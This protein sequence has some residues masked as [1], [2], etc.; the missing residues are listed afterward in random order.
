[1]EEEN[2]Q[3]GYGLIALY[4]QTT[5]GVDKVRNMLN[6]VRDLV[7]DLPFLNNDQNRKKEIIKTCINLVSFIKLE[8]DAIYVPPRIFGIGT[9]Q[10]RYEN[11]NKSIKKKKSV[12][13]KKSTKKKSVFKKKRT[14]S[15]K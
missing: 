15:R 6:S 12:K 4:G 13:K 1:M 8:L 9:R 14:G 2:E 10:R 5:I 7:E 11:I 3:D